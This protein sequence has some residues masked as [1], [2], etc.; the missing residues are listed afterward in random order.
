MKNYIVS[1]GYT[2]VRP[3]FKYLIVMKMVLVLLLALLA[4]ARAD[5]SAQTLTIKGKSMSLLHVFREIKKQTGYTVICNAEIIA[6]A[7]PIDVSLKD[8]PLREGLSLLLPSQDLSYEILKKSIIIQ[9]IERPTTVVNADITAVNLQQRMVSGQVRTMSGQLLPGASVSI[10]GKA[11]ETKTDSDGRYTISATKDDILTFSFLGYNTQTQVVGERHTIDMILEVFQAEI[12]DVVVIGYGTQSKRELTTA[13]AQVKGEE[14]TKVVSNTISAGL[15]GKATGLRVHST[16]GAPGAQAEITIRGGSSIN[17]SN[18]PLVLI[19]GMP[20]ALATVPPQDVE[21]IEVLKDAASTAIYGARASNGIILVTTKKGKAGKTKVTGNVYYGY[22]NAGRRIKR[23]DAEQFLS[24]VRPAIEQSSYRSWLTLA[25]PAGTGNDAKSNFSTRYLQSGEEV[26]L[27]WKTMPD[28][29]DPTKTLVFEDTDV[30]NNVFQGGNTMNV[31]V[32]ATGGT[33]KLKYMSSIGY[34][35]DEGFVKMSDWDN[36]TLRSNLSYQLSDRLRMHTNLG[37]TKSYSNAIHNQANIFSRSIHM[38]PTLRSVMPDGTIPGGRDANFNNPLH[39]LDN[40]T[41]NSNTFRFMGKVGIEWDIIQGLVARADGYYNPTYSHREYFQKANMYNSQRPAEYFGDLDQSNQFEGTLTYNKNWGSHKVNA[42]IGASSLSYNIYGYNARAQGGSSD[43]IITLNASSEYLGASSTRERERLNSTFGRIS[44]SFKS[45]YLLSGSLRID[46]SSKFINDRRVGYFPGVSAG[47][48]ISEEEFLKKQTWINQLKIRTSYGLTGNN[49]VGRYDYQ[50]LWSIA[51]IYDGGA[52]A[53][54][55]SMPNRSLRWEN[56]AQI[57]LGLDISLL[58]DDLVNLTLDYYS[59]NTNNL[60][61]SR[62]LPNTSGFGSIESNVGKVRFYGYEAAAT[63]KL[64]RK[65]DFQWQLGANISYNLN[66]VLALPSNG[67][68]KNRI[69]G[70]RF[71][72][73]SGGVGGIAEGERLY[74]IVGYRTDFLIDNAD[75]A[76]AARYDDRAGGWDPVTR[77]STVG[78]KFAGDYEWQDRNGDN[79][80]TADDQFVLGYHIPTTTGG[81]NTNL[82]YRGIELYILTDFALGHHIYDRQISML[83]AYGENGYIVPTVDVLDAWKV[84]GDAAR[85]SIPRFD[86]QDGSNLGQWNWYRTSN[87][88][89]YKGNYLAIREVKLSY[90]FSEKI[91]QRYG[92]GTL[93]VYAS[94]LN[95]HYFTAYPGYITE[96]SGSG[97]NVGDNNY[98]NPR[99]FTVGLNL[100]F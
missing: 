18:S 13:I 95:L 64:L 49:A 48:L 30:E 42:L 87:L 10:K 73:G 90:G 6:E 91:L 12:E 31:H 24:I 99:V 4:Q 77:K 75:Q 76:T 47:Y 38:A 51:N 26:P 85:T 27:G 63:V 50:G 54:P 79:R 83:N 97:R 25:H 20:G 55:S 44:Y 59:K 29:L 100:G 23:L 34:T 15:K 94:G 36:F 93:T 80:I 35:K 56:S 78:K 37:F 9:R 53:T 41:Y 68:D 11:L 69:G 62:P 22:Q 32:T 33:E 52:A 88:N 96:Y 61:F 17:K 2:R 40:I 74:S 3:L 19:D 16:S 66:K 5:V 1:L 39:I 8:K 58:K 81:L 46:A 92:L 65:A 89:A 21:S 84:P 7:G 71:A 60:L 43:D 14:L 28:P 72:D 57:D 86:V 45:K 70:I 82:N 67:I 98:P